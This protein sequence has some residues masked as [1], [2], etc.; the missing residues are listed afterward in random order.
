MRGGGLIDGAVYYCKDCERIVP[1][2]PVRNKYAYQ[3]KV[4]GTKNVAFG[5]E[6]SIRSYFHVIDEPPAAPAAGGV[7]GVTPPMVSDAGQKNV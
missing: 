3:C 7:P 2:Y 5:S 1:V 4:C 6:R